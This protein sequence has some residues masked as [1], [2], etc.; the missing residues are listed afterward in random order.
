MTLTE[1]LS[2]FEL[3]PPQIIMLGDSTR[4]RKSDPVTS[5]IAADVSSKHLHETK[6]R[7]LQII[8]THG[9]LVGSE[10]NDLYAITAARLNWRRVA[11]DTPRKRSQELLADGFLEVTSVRT[12][13]GNNLPER[14][15][16]LTDAGREA[17]AHD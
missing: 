2:M 14:A 12:A 6:R 7:V 17:L 10:V 4:A 1:S 11:F 5:H 9:S 15:M 13:E 3:E 8:D 16:G